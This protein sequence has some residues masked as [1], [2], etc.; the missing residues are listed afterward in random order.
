VGNL[1]LQRSTISRNRAEADGILGAGA[2]GGGI[3]IASSGKSFLFVNSTLSGNVVAS[4]S[5]NGN[6]D[7]LGGGIDAADSSGSLSISSSTLVRNSVQADGTPGQVG[8]GA[9]AAEGQLVSPEQSIL[10]LNTA[11]KGP[12]CLGA[13]SSAG[14]NVVGPLKGCTFTAQ[15]SDKVAVTAPKL[16]P[17][18]PNGGPTQTVALLAGSPA[19]DVTPASR[20]ETSIDQRGVRRPQPKGGRCDAGAF[21]RKP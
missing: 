6:V 2:R 18:G 21:E 14:G 10:S 19:L 3:D 5:G 1:T 15:P 7:A 4:R 13:V 20:C 12:N 9:V 8:G 16:G 17:L 11:P